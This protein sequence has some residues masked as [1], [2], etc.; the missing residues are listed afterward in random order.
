V[1]NKEFIICV[2]NGLVFW[3]DRFV[4]CTAPEKRASVLKINVD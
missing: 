3:N 4:R 1:V 2:H